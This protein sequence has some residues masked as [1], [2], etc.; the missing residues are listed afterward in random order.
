MS[1]LLSVVGLS[2]LIGCA[3]VNPNPVTI[4][5]IVADQDGVKRAALVVGLTS[6]DPASYGGWNGECP[7]CDVDADVIALLCKEQGLSVTKLLTKQATI[8]A[9]YQKAKLITKELKAGDLFVFYISCHGG[10]VEDKNKDEVDL[11]DET[12]CLY[13]GELTDDQLAALWQEIPKGVRVLFISDSCNSGTNYKYKPR[14]LKRSAQEYKGQLI[15]FG[16]CPDGKSSFGSEQGGTF[17]TA[18]IDAWS[19][20]NTY[21]NWFEAALKK[22]PENQLPVYEEFGQV[23]D[24]FRNGEALK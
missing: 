20:G 10:Q 14:S 18:L 3:N 11:L 9:V 12:I 13:D 16:G 23:T 22:M 4:E 21:L 2:L 24:E 1:K 17:T 6:V 5:D 15:H 7:G 19:D 8:L